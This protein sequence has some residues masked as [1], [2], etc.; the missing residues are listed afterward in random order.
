M[1]T[2]E[3]LKANELLASL[4]DDQLNAIATLSR[5]D[6]EAV[7]GQRFGEVYRQ[8]D[9]TIEK[10][11]GVKR[12]GDE[13]TYLYLERA[14]NELNERVKGS[15]ALAQQVSELTKEKARLEKVIADGG[16]DAETKKALAQAQRDLTSVTRQ[17]NELK[18][19]SEREKQ[20]HINE[21]FGLR[22]NAELDAAA[23]NVKW[24]SGYTGNVKDVLLSQAIEN[25]RKMSP[26]EIDD[27]KGGKVIVFK[28]ADGEI[29]RNTENQLYPYTAG[30][31]LVKELDSMGVLE[32]KRTVSGTGTEPP[33]G[34]G[35]TD[36]YAVDVSGVKT[37]AEA[38]DA[39]AAALMARGLTNGS[40]EFDT[41]VQNAWK[42]NN[43]NK[44]PEK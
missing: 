28:G 17:Y 32:R 43:I 31:L 44:L 26:E 2:T 25:V 9:A 5:N 18:E 16:S 1:L 15:A 12:N 30:E 8:M 37:Q 39:I 13:K 20:N 40:K 22:V 24:K 41:A 27:G 42:D 29:L 36:K 33:K 19:A 38:Y 3:I 35:S 6:E 34:G 21:L 11:T 4:T 23:K 14:A 7:I 10:A